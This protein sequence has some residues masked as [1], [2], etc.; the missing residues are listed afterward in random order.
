MILTFLVGIP[1]DVS[2]MSS[3]AN[4]FAI[5]PTLPFPEYDLSSWQDKL[6][7]KKIRTTTNETVRS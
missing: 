1:L 2:T 3:D 6:L 5:N 4:P 7:G